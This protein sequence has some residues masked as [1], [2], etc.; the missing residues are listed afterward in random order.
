MNRPIGVT[1]LAAG[2]ALIGVYELYR[3]L[4]FMGVASFNFGLG[5]S[6]E[7]NQPQWG[8]YGDCPTV[9]A[10]GESCQ[11]TCI[12]GYSVVGERTS[13]SYGKLSAQTC[14]ESPCTLEKD[15][16]GWV[17]TCGPGWSRR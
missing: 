15:F 3:M 17:G 7:F 11:I 5:N 13:C 1:L 12:A 16:Y 10:A 4:I 6:V 14:Q 2:A 9:L 8:R